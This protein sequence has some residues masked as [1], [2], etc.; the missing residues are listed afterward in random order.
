MK[1]NV[2]VPPSH[3]EA[4][5]VY[6]FGVTDRLYRTAHRTS[7]T[8]AREELLAQK[9]MI[10]QLDIEQVASMYLN[11]QL[12]HMYVN[13]VYD[14][15]QVCGTDTTISLTVSEQGNDCEHFS[16]GTVE[17]FIGRLNKYAQEADAAAR[18]TIEQIKHDALC[19]DIER[20]TKNYQFVAGTK[21]YDVTFEVL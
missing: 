7:D 20:I 1:M 3:V 11:E 14:A 12:Q 16:F 8:V 17:T 5:K 10:E 9:A 6:R 15:S 19:I 4:L 13:E 2:T 18:E 21:Q